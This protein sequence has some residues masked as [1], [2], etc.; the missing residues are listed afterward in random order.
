MIDQIIK[1]TLDIVHEGMKHWNEAQR[2]RFMDQHFSILKKIEKFR[3]RQFPNYYDSDL[4]FS[5]KELITFL[6]AYSVELKKTN[7]NPSN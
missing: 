2:T 5:K 3:A 6:E 4:D 1:V 7:S